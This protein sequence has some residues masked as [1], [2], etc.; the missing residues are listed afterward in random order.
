MWVTNCLTVAWLAGGRSRGV[1]PSEALQ[2]LQVCE[3]WTI[4][5]DGRVES[6]L[7]FSFSCRAATVV[8]IFVID[9]IRKWV[10]TPIGSRPPARV[11]PAPPW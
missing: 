2:H 11:A 7:P 6:R 8:S 1:S 3:L 9:M 10:S 4:V 5:G